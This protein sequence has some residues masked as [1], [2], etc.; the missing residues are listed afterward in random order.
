[1]K[2]YSYKLEEW[3]LDWAFSPIRCK[4][5]LILLLM[6]AIKVMLI[7]EPALHSTLVDNQSPRMTLYISKISRIFFHTTTKHF[8]VCFPFKVFAPEGAP[9]SFQTLLSA[10]VDSRLT[11]AIISLIETEKSLDLTDIYSFHDVI[12]IVEDEISDIWVTLRELMTFEDGYLRYD[13]DPVH[14][15]GHLHP[16]YHL[17]IFYSSQ[18]TFKIGLKGSISEADLWKALEPSEECLYLSPHSNP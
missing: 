11:S 15:N 8:S 3:E 4:R 12:S 9:P 17:D 2:K 6:K 18:P 5:E 1:M 13:H 10:P 14:V 16:L 7:K